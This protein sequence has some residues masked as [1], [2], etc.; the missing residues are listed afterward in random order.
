MQLSEVI[1]I[2]KNK[3]NNLAFLRS[4]AAKS[5]NLAEVAK[6]DVEIEETNNTL[7]QLGES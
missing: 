4:E 3:A 6:L 5:G 7:Q 2:I 1:E